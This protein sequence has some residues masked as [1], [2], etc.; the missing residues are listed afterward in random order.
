MRKIIYDIGLKKII[1]SL[2]KSKR[3][4]K[5][6]L[7]KS[8]DSTKFKIFN[9]SDFLVSAE[10]DK[11]LSLTQNYRRFLSTTNP[12]SGSSKGGDSCKGPGNDADSGRSGNYNYEYFKKAGNLLRT[13]C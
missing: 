1:D 3:V 8:M 11:W 4:V 10:D 6:R 2:I 12:F 9:I 7:L 5:I 13:K